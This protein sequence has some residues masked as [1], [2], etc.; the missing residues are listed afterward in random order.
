MRS[1]DVKTDHRLLFRRLGVCANQ[2]SA[3][4]GTIQL[5]IFQDFEKQERDRRLQ[6]AML[7]VRKKFG[8][9]AVFKGMN[10]MEG[11]TALERNQQ[12]GGHRG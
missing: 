4:D 1:F 2:V 7:A 10:L 12:V 8:T 6:G 11:A 5:S 3:D 9:N